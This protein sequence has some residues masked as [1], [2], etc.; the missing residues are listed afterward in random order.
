MGE[1]GGVTVL[2]TRHGVLIPADRQLLAAVRPEHRRDHRRIL[3]VL[4]A[5][6]IPLAILV[7]EQLP[8]RRPLG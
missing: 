1:P 8:L 6:T 7:V 2:G 3:A 4:V 5:A